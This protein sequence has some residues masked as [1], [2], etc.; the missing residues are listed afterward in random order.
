[1]LTMP[2]GYIDYSPNEVELRDE[3]ARLKLELYSAKAKCEYLISML[4]P[5]NNYRSF[6][7]ELPEPIF[8]RG[9][10]VM[11]VEYLLPLTRFN[12]IN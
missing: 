11:F 6:R 10:R 8:Y 3:I 5:T 1:M 7:E 9:E 12:N 4:P 2:H